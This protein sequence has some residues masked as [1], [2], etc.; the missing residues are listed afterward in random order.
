MGQHPNHCLACNRWILLGCIRML[1]GMARTKDWRTCCPPYG[2]ASSSPTPNHW[3][4]H[5]VRQNHDNVLSKSNNCIRTAFLTGIIFSSIVIYLPQ[6]FQTVNGFSPIQAGER[7]LPFLLVSAFGATFSGVALSKKST[8]C[9]AF[10][11][12]GTALQVLG[13]GL[14]SSLSTSMEVPAVEYV[15]QAILGMGTGSVLSATFFLARIEIP[16]REDIGESSFDT[17]CIVS[18]LLY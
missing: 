4:L 14:H 11:M 8:F 12:A 1:G 9:S 18:L 13:L 10:I 6:R 7:V 2:T 15:Y 16:R 5:R 17:L 3:C